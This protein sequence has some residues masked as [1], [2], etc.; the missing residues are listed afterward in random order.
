M[1]KRR[2]TTSLIIRVIAGGREGA[3]IV[4]YD[5]RNGAVHECRDW[6]EALA[7]LRSLSER[8]GLR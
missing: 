5:L 1:S 8:S 3:R 4:L 7:R 2:V 6:D